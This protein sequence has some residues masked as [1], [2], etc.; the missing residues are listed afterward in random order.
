MKRRLA[1]L[2]GAALLGLVP[3]VQAE[4]VHLLMGNPQG[5]A[6]WRG[7][8]AAESGGQAG[9][10]AYPAPNALGFLAAILTHAALAQ[11]AQSAQ[12]NER[13]QKADEVLV[14]YAAQLASQ[15]SRELALAALVG[16]PEL[17]VRVLEEGGAV[18]S[19][20]LVLA[21]QPVFSLSA[22]QRT[23][24][25]DNQ[26]MLYREGE[27]ARPQFSNVVRVVSDPRP[28][29]DPAAF[30]A[31]QGQTHLLDEGQRLFAHS[32]ESVLLAG[33]T[34]A[35]EVPA[36]TQRYLFGKD[37]RAERGRVMAQACGRVL[38][39]TLREGLLSVPV[40]TDGEACARRYRL[41]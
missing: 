13:Q 9:G 23:L 12:R 17:Q 26:V 36:K 6:V 38:V 35:D 21:V 24:V 3:G 41:S 5:P 10:M 25:L 31:E 16:M 18:P 4:P 33:A 1:G 14:P 8:P 32:L 30:W 39:R 37:E 40:R 29:E 27:A 34:S 22:D 19:Q 11:G 20:A 15:S 2:L 7:I 28:E